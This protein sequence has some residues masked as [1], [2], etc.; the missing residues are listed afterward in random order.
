MNNRFSGGINK[1]ETEN[2]E[3]QNEDTK[4]CPDCEKN[5]PR[6]IMIGRR[7]TCEPCRQ[8][9][10]HDYPLCNR[11]GLH[12]PD[13]AT[14]NLRNCI[15]CT[16]ISA[17]NTKLC[18]VCNQNVPKKDFPSRSKIC[19]T[20][21]NDSVPICEKCKKHRPDLKDSG[22]V[23]CEECRQAR[24]EKNKI[25]RQKK[26]E[27]KDNETQRTC[28]QCKNTYPMEKFTATK[29]IYKKCYQC[30][31]ILTL[32]IVCKNK[33]AVYNYKLDESSGSKDSE[34][35]N[36]LS[37]K[38]THCID[39]KL[40]GMVDNTRKLCRNKDCLKRACYG[41]ENDNLQ[42][43]KTHKTDN[44]YNY[45][46]KRCD[47]GEIATYGI[48]LTKRATHCRTHKTDEMLLI[49]KRCEHP[50]CLKIPIFNLPG[51]NKGR[52]CKNHKSQD[53]IIIYKYTCTYQDE[54]NGKCNIVAK[55]N[56][57]EE[58]KAV[59]CKNHKLDGM[60]YIN[61]CK[62]AHPLCIIQASF[63]FAGKKPKYCKG[64][65]ET[66]MVNVR[67]GTYCI[68]P[69]CRNRNTYNYEG[70]PPLYCNTHKKPCMIDKYEK[71]CN[72]E[73][74][75]YTLAGFGY[76]GETPLY[77]S[78]HKRDGMVNLKVRRCRAENCKNRANYNFTGYPSQYCFIHRQPDM[79]I[80]PNR[81]C[82]VDGCKNR[83]V[84]GIRSPAHCEDHKRE[85]E[86]DLR[87]RKC[88]KCGSLEVCSPESICYE[89]CIA[90]NLYKRYKKRKELE[91]LNFLQKN[92][93]KEIHSYD[94][95]VD[96]TCSL[97]RPDIVY[98][99]L[100][101]M[102]IVEV[103]EYQHNS[104]SGECEIT[105]MKQITYNYALPCVFIRYNPD[106]YESETKGK[107]EE[108][109]S[110]SSG[111]SNII[112]RLKVLQ[113]YVQYCI[114]NIPDKFSKVVYLFYD[115]YR[116]NKEDMTYDKFEDIEII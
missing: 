96:T 87:L 66:G 91:V 114:S 19:N 101:H 102:V 24:N 38:T 53:M 26:K 67:G 6:S 70:Q 48:D 28:I 76:E 58:K 79:I 75:C 111:E 34:S 83:S 81:M 3:F 78:L 18:R 8:G 86:T 90:D 82:S 115:G 4:W 31:F 30:R 63:N 13:L 23:K 73:E 54:I 94:K 97:H 100:T 47:C 59:F 37:R 17:S 68:E 103:D 98:D 55:Y 40:P 109:I 64:H 93:S 72:N 43:C 35:K 9:L 42:F 21:L 85:D 116:Y 108:D 52:F 104:R 49:I 51:E 2:K 7:K 77:C 44:M 15:V 14:S 71:Y 99:C 22:Y 88:L 39:C 69:G 32:C 95:T 107:D 25:K 5:V 1:I 61:Y 41:T 16:N 45:D 36:F 84:Y 92:I 89:Y 106:N 56:Y 20:C 113:K 65:S 46:A 62:C 57:Q 110:Q 74:K 60:V 105:R 12:K 10:N 33:K 50:G 112:P 29:K 80:Y 11:C 27:E